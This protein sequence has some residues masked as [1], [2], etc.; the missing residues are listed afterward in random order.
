MDDEE[1]ELMEGSTLQ[2]IC[3]ED[4]D[5]HSV[6]YLEERI[7]MLK[8]EITRTEAAIAGKKGARSAA[9]DFFK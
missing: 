3:Q 1:F 6:E 7:G 9:E 8:A 4:L 2:D 5:V